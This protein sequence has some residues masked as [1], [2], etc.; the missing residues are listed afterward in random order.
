MTDKQKRA[1]I[2]LNGLWND[3][4]VNE[5]EYFLLMD[6]VVGTPTITIGEQ[7]HWNLPKIDTP[8]TVMYGCL[9]D[10]ITYANKDTSVTTTPD[11]CIRK[12]EQL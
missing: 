6:F 2:L 10:G 3:N 11:P 12:E 4:S 9:T 1:I 5:E 7:E 8:I